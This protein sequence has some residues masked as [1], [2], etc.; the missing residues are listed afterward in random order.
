M[1]CL[2]YECDK[3]KELDH[4]LVK[5]NSDCGLESVFTSLLR[6]LSAAAPD[7]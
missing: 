2:L 3:G 5:M 6:I 7:Q 1:I 4:W